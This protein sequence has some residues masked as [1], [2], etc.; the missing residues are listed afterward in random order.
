M[1][2]YVPR[3]LLCGDAAQ[4]KQTI[5]NKPAEIVGQITFKRAGDEAQLF[6]DGRPLTSESLKRLLNGAAE[7]LIFTD[8]LELRDCLETFPLNTQVLS[9]VTFAKKIR[10]G[11]FSYETLLFLRELLRQKN[12]PGRVLDFDCYFAHSD[13]RTRF[14]LDV[15]LDC[16]AENFGGVLFPIMENLYGKIYRTFDACRY[17][18]FG[19]VI[20]TA[21][22][23]PE[24][25]IDAL[26]K[27]DSLSENIL[28]FVRRGSALENWLAANENIFAQVE[29]FDVR[30]GAW[31]LIKKFVPPADVG[32]YVVT[33]K[34]VQLAALPEGYKIIHAGH[35]RA[36]QDFGYAGD[37]TGDNISQLNRYLDE[38]TALYWLW[39]NTAHTHT[40][41][42]HYR[43]FFTSN[44]VQ[45]DLINANQD[46]DATK[47]LSAAEIQQILRDH[48]IILNTEFIGD[49]NQLELMLYSTGQPDLVRVSEKIVRKHLAAAQPDY[50]DAYD[51]V[52]NGFI[53]FICG[54][55]ITRRNILDAYCKWLFS[56]VLDA[57]IEIRDN[58]ILGGQKLEDVPHVYSRMMSYF[59]ERMLT[60]WLT[61]NHL[62]IKTLPIMYREDV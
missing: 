41:I 24:E 39:K 15:K 47:I 9:A 14:D 48:D 5:G 30:N 49:R 35:E 55:F 54:I 46:F 12:F 4:F 61:K 44:V 43:R 37:D 1:A 8:P 10:D 11:F 13:F 18:I 34:D 19:A 26:I 25:F 40:G 6:F 16:V 20:L 31:S 52:M 58:I 38:I 42:V 21:E 50:L 59:S 62:R 60:I 51:A 28:A 3:V 22:R 45:T 36:Q 17:H 53:F 2:N 33:H 7:F 23:S 32:V 56:F 57:T 29:S 27:I